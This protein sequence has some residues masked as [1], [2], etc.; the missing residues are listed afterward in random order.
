MA[1]TFNLQIVTPEREVFNHSVESV[2]L[3]GMAGEFG[4]LRGHAPLI[5]ALE[6]GPIEARE[7]DATEHLFSIGGGFFQVSEDRAILLADSAIEPGAIDLEHEAE[8]ER[9]ARERLAEKMGP[10]FEREREE[11]ER[12]LKRAQSRRRVALRRGPSLT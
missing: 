1:G 10:G 6:P 12:A 3:P 9:E 11:A 7:A 8:V 5:A 4:V 2:R